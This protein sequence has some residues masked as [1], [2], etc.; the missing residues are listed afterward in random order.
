[1]LVTRPSVTLT[2]SRH[3]GQD[4]EIQVGQ[5]VAFDLVV[6]NSGDTTLATVPMSDTFDSAALSFTTATVAPDTTGAG[7]L[8]WNN[9]GPLAQG[10]STTVTVTFT[11][12]AV[13]AGQV[14]TDT[15]TVTGVRDVY[16]DPAPDD[17]DSADVRIT[18]PG[19]RDRQEAPRGSG[20]SGAGRPDRDVRRHRHQHR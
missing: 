7:S 14:T 18:T 8:G 1:M 12:V 15:A 11:A 3:T 6:T 4:T 17:A 19:C 13:P 2:K 16:N 20:H 5:T 9:V 10:E